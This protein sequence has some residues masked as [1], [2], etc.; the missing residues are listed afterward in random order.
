VAFFFE[1]LLM[2]HDRSAVEIFCYSDAVRPDDVT[3]RLQRHADHWRDVAGQ[4]DEQFIAQ[5]RADRIDI[6]VD[7]AGHTAGN[8]LRAFAARPAPVQV[9]Y[10]GYPNTTG[11]PAVDYRF[12]DALADPPGEADTL[13]TEKLIRLPR[14]AWCYRPPDPS[15]HHNPLPAQ[16]SGAVTFGSFNMPAKLSEETLDLWSQLLAA[17]PNSKL[18]LKFAALSEQS[19][20]DH[21][22]RLF[23]A[24]G[25]AESRLILRGRDEA[26]KHHLRS[27]H[28]IDIALDTFPYHGT[29]TTCDALWMGVPVVTLIGN[30]HVSRVGASLLN[31]V[32]L[33]DLV[34][35]TREQF[36][37]T[38]AALAGDLP[39]LAKLRSTLRGVMQKSPLMDAAGLA[40]EIE[41]S[42]REI[43]Q[44]SVRRV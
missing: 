24:R 42:Y 4:S 41:R 33:D 16:E 44:Q 26:V 43:W 13:Y 9:T 40:R 14:C 35:T 21:F 39:R 29:T 25:V 38:A 6:L 5:V 36:I 17:V 2:A 37:A 8:R 18:M 10:L 11:V 15:P 34:T 27:Y 28:E 3:A 31:A 1:P 32:G 23:A 19:M 30:A 12:T 7:L 22:A 20:R